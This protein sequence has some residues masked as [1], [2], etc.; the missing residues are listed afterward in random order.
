[1]RLASSLALAF[2]VASLAAGCKKKAQGPPPPAEVH[3]TTVSPTNVPVYREWIGTME[4]LVNAQIR[5]QASGYLQSQNYSEGKQVKKGDLLFE[6]DPRPFQAALEQARSK[7]AQDE[8]EQARTQWDVKRYEPLAKENAISQQEYNNAVQANVAA[9]ALVKADQAAVRAAEL[10]LGFTRILSPIDG[11]AGTA[12][13]QIGDL[14]G[15]NGAV[16]T[17]VSTMDPIKVY[18]TASEQ[19]Y[20]A[21]R[22]QY[23]NEVERASHEQELQFQLILADGSTYVHEGKFLF[24]GREVNPTTGTIQL[25][26]QFPNPENV[27]RPGQFARVRAR[28]QTRIGALLVPQRAVNELQGSYQVAVVDDQ[29]KVHLQTVKVGE[30]I[31]SNW[32]IEDGLKPGNRVVVEGLQKAKEGATVAPKPFVEQRNNAD[33][34]SAV[35]PRLNASGET[36]AA[37]GESVVA[38][39]GWG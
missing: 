13:A 37:T 24:A 31:G 26:A 4:G 11:V 17:T 29:N 35:G 10:N 18:F 16:L 23:S 7:L 14:V 38:R 34:R 15:P 1:M 19:A 28:V 32:I 39:Q 12:Q 6:I 9:E 36:A 21:Y 22:R 30:R 25:A 20:L 5:A 27:L 2:L 33:L 8:A 3:V